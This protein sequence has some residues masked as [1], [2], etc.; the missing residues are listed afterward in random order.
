MPGARVAAL[1]D[2]DPVRLE[3]V[4][5]AL[6]VASRHADHRSLLEDP[7]VEVVAVCVPAAMHA[8]IA[9]DVLEAGRHLLVEKPLALDLDDADRLAAAGSAA[10][11][12]GICSAVGLNLRSHRLLQEARLGLAAGAVGEV[13]ALRTAFTSQGRAR[14]GEAPWRLRPEEGGGALMEV[15]S[16]HVDL[17]RFLLGDEIAEVG[18]M[19][20]ADGSTAALTGRMRGGALVSA[21]VSEVV[22]QDHELTAHG[23]TGRLQVS[24]Y[25]FDGLQITVGDEVP[26]APRA[27]VRSARR[28]AAT[29]PG[30]IG[31][32]RAGGDYVGSY[33]AQWERMLAA[34]RGDGPVPATLADGRAALAAI[35]SAM[36]AATS[37]RTV[38]IEDAPRRVPD[39]LAE[40][41]A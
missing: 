35:F 23:D 39:A 6:S 14:A 10:A 2:P 18:A 17:W 1:A 9:L 27:R 7:A 11:E 20:S 21:T 36:E 40:V 33:A 3:R 8:P 19:V 4:G 31:A 24:A 37:G 34:V 12:D 30:A 15:G 28:T 41:E 16:H 22:A 32:L 38:S 5:E 29:L 13:R 26:G 25:R